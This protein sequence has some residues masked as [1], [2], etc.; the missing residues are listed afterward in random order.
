MNTDFI[1]YLAIAL[2]MACFMSILLY[3]GLKEYNDRDPI[4]RT[5][6]KNMIVTA[7]IFL[8]IIILLIGRALE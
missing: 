8:V 5:F 6:A 3:F 4:N 7:V 1:G 2:I